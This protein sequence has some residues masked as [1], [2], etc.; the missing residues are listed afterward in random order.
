MLADHLSGAAKLFQTANAKL[1]ASAVSQIM[2]ADAIAGPDMVDI[3]AGF[4]DP[5]C[6]FVPQ[7][8]RQMVSP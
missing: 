1:T 7:R 6:N 8:H 4:F 5:T 3:G 2:Y